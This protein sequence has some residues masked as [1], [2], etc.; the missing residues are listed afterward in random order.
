MIWERVPKDVSIGSETLQLGVYDAVAHFNIGSQTAINILHRLGL[1]PAE[2]CLQEFRMSD[3]L[4]IQKGN[5]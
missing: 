5:V 2:F 1:E 3:N 4:R